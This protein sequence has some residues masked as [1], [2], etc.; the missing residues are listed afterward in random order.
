M[1]HI[2]LE[3]ED[4]PKNAVRVTL[5]KWIVGQSPSSMLNDSGER[6]SER[7]ET[8][9]SVDTNCL[10]AGVDAKKGQPFALWRI[11]PAAACHR[12]TVHFQ[13]RVRKKGDAGN[14]FPQ[15]LQMVNASE[16]PM[17]LEP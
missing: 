9:P 16:P 8:L 13:I 10:P 11:R 2:R 14:F 6:L 17:D 15:K 5:K 1:Y 4:L 12:R 3:F 7:Y